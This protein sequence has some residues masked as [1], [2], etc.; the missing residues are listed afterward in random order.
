[1]RSYADEKKVCLML[2]LRPDLLEQGPP[3]AIADTVRK[4]ILE[5][6]GKGRF[7]FLINLVPVRAPV[8][9]VHAAVA[10]ARQFGCH[11]ISADPEAPPFRPPEFLPFDAWVSKEGLPI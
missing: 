6:A 8:E 3:Q 7:A 11:P 1:V 2:N 9:N 4:V 10:A 5:G